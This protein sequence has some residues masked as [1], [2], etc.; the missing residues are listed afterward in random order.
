MDDLC[1]NPISFNG[2]ALETERRGKG[3]RLGLA[4]T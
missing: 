1:H 3:L 4:E 2:A